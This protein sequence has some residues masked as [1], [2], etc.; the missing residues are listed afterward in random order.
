MLHP[1]IFL[2]GNQAGGC[3]VA[4]AVIGPKVGN[5]LDR[6]LVCH[7]VST[8]TGNHTLTSKPVA[9]LQSPIHLTSKPLNCGNTL[10]RIHTGAGRTCKLQTEWSQL[11]TRTFPL[12]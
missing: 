9:N 4:G 7:R 3:G 12:L 6:L 10:E 8:R 11:G 2:I 5:I 1:S